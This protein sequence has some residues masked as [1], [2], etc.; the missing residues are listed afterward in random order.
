[1]KQK[2]EDE[3][4]TFNEEWLRF[5]TD[6][7]LEGLDL[8]TFTYADPSVLGAVSDRGSYK[9]VIVASALLLEDENK[10]RHLTWYVRHAWIRKESKLRMVNKHFD[11]SMQYKS[12]M[13]GIEA[14]GFQATLKDDYERVE[15]ERLKHIPIKLMP[16]KENK[17]VRISRHTSTMERGRIKFIRGHSDQN[18]LVEQFLDFPEGEVDGPDALIGLIDMAESR[19][20]KF[21]HKSTARVLEG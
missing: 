4:G 1:M 14:V 2:P 6:D 13:D 21:K 15:G 19:Y 9:A 20:F 3:D 17:I 12:V 5:Y 10:V 18:L 11:L 16:Q 8:I 7:E